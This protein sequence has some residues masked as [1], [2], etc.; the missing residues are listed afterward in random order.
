[1]QVGKWGVIPSFMLV[2]DLQHPLLKKYD[3]DFDM[4]DFLVGAKQ[5]VVEMTKAICSE[6]VVALRVKE[7]T[8]SSSIT[9]FLKQCLTPNLYFNFVCGVSM[10]EDV[11]RSID[12]ESL[13]VL[14]VHM[15]PV[16]E[17]FLESRE[18]E[19]M[20]SVF[21]DNGARSFLNLELRDQVEVNRILRDCAGI[22]YP[23]GSILMQV[24]VLCKTSEEMYDYL[25]DSDGGSRSLRRSM[26]TF[27]ACVS[28][29]VETNWIV[30]NYSSYIL[31]MIP[32]KG[33]W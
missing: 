30:S 10:T 22:N 29:H 11:I 12:L 3:V 4:D 16:D 21:V 17:A 15:V 24:D 8:S 1:M 25:R 27:E 20:K 2:T 26:W 33:F 31:G 32:V 5:A 19:S 7:E 9:T 6:E 14:R 28:G 18:R 13:L 23:L